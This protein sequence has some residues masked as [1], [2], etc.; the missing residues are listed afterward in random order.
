M[1][2]PSLC[3]ADAA[4]KE[5]HRRPSSARV[6]V[7][8]L[9]DQCT[10]FCNLA[11]KTQPHRQE[12]GQPPSPSFASL[13]NSVSER[14]TG[15]GSRVVMANSAKKKNG[16]IFQKIFRCYKAVEIAVR[17]K[18]LFNIGPGYYPAKQVRWFGGD[19]KSPAC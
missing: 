4:L 7:H 5:A 6:V 11:L 18:K 2:S 9:L 19:P 12:Q 13:V 17:K 8:P 3:D 1:T 14:G 15:E 16:D 10:T